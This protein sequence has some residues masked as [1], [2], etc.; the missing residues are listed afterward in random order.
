[1]GKKLNNM[2]SLFFKIL[3]SILSLDMDE[4]EIHL[5]TA[6]NINLEKLPSKVP[7][8]NARYHLYRFKHTH[9]GDYMEDVVFIYS[10]PG[11]NCSIRERMLYSSCKNPL[12]EV[13]NSLGLEIIKKVNNI[14]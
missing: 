8:S 14:P 12:I 7:E 9:E 6:E 11:Y 3:N 1:M 13:I 10:M 5:V 4:E 2:W